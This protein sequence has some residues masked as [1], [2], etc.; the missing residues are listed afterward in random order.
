MAGD[1]A[2]DKLITRSSATRLGMKDNYARKRVHRGILD[3]RTTRTGAYAYH[4]GLT[5][6]NVA[7]PRHPTPNQKQRP[8]RRSYLVKGW[9]DEYEFQDA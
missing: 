8:V 2:K 1:A 3:T 9:P 7:S 5:G 4:P 6:D